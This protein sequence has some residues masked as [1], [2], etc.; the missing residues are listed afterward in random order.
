MY[1]WQHLTYS[2]QQQPSLV[3][4]QG[5][6]SDMS[7]RMPGCCDAQKQ[8]QTRTHPP[9]SGAARWGQASLKQRHWPSAS[10]HTTSRA[11]TLSSVWGG[12]HPSS[13]GQPAG[14]QRRV[15]AAGLGQ[16]QQAAAVAGLKIEVCGWSLLQAG[17]SWG[18]TP[19]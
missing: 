9:D 18:Q 5:E 14:R 11:P 3:W 15:S 7:V 13:P 8:K 1:R 12:W 2:W 6:T 16:H 19:G 4:L 17:C 10:R